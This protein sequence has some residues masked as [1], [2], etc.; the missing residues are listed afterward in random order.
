[1]RDNNI[2]LKFN[3]RDVGKITNN[4]NIQAPRRY[5]KRISK[6]K[7]SSLTGDTGDSGDSGPFQHL[8][9]SPS[10]IPFGQVRGTN[11]LVDIEG[12]NIR[13]I[14]DEERQHIQ[15]MRQQYFNQPAS[16]RHMATQTE[17]ESRDMGSQTESGNVVAQQPQEFTGEYQELPESVQ[18]VDTMEAMAPTLEGG[19][20]EEMMPAEE[21]PSQIYEAP[22]ETRESGIESKREDL[23]N[24]W[25]TFKYA[26][27]NDKATITPGTPMYLQGHK[28]RRQGE[29]MSGIFKPNLPPNPR[30]NIDQGKYGTTETGS[31][32]KEWL[33]DDL[34]EEW[35]KGVLAMYYGR[36]GKPGKI[37]DK[38][39]AVVRN[40]SSANPE[41]GESTP[42]VEARPVESNP[43]FETFGNIT[44]FTQK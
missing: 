28:G 21:E 27:P 23:I 34:I 39:M 14:A 37:P 15:K 26:D 10:Q 11:P 24:K 20:L 7:Y 5:R 44:K 17:R 31:Y 41:R 12:Q 42:I 3:T 8:Y 16:V 4:I 6:S 1:M 9:Q 32:R 22:Q 40:A 30:K 43:Q 35:N 36:K 33:E 19:Y 29:V 13:R 25:K 38:V 2:H 18:N